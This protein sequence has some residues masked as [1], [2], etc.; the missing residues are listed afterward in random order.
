MKHTDAF[1]F[2]DVNNRNGFWECPSPKYKLSSTS[3]SIIGYTAITDT[4]TTLILMDTAAVRAYYSQVSVATN[5]EADNGYIF[6]CDADLPDLSFLIG[7]TNCATAP[8]SSSAFPLLGRAK[9][10]LAVSRLSVVQES[11]TSMVMCS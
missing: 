5:S 1:V 4:E 10:A 3:G 6:S 7:S 8:G 2:T 9:C 11:R